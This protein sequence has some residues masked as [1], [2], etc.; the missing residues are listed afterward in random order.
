MRG[1]KSLR[2][3]V[4]TILLIASIAGVLAGV[5]FQNLIG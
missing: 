3:A 1:Y 4:T 2:L 5:S